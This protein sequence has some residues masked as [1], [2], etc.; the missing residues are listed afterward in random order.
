MELYY[1]EEEKTTSKKSK[2]PILIGVFI[3][4]LILLTALI[5]YFILYL[6]TSV[7]KVNIDGISKNDFGKI[8]EISETDNGTE[9]YFPIRK[10][11][12]Y[13]GYSDYSG[14]YLTKSE[15]TTKCYVDNNE[16]IAM[17]TLNSNS[18]ILIRDGDLNEE[19]SI[20]KKIFEKDNELYTTEDGIEK[21]FNLVFEYNQEKNTINIY[22]LDYLVSAYSTNLN[23]PEMGEQSIN[24]KKAILNGLLI[25][26]NEDGNKCGVINVTTGKYVLETKYDSISYLPYLKQFLVSSNGKYGVMD[27]NG[28]IKLKVAYDDIQ[29]CDNKN[30][31]YVVK[32]NALY[33][34]VDSSGTV[35]LPSDFDKIGIDKNSFEQNRIDN[36]YILNSEVIPVYSNGLWGFYNI[37]G[38]KITN[39][40]YTDVGC[41]SVSVTNAYPVVEIPSFKLIV[42]KVDQQHY[43][44]IDTKGQTTEIPSILDSVY[45][46]TDAS[47]GKN[48]YYISY[49]GKV[50][51][52]EQ[53]FASTG[54]TN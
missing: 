48:T 50:G 31:L 46:K 13:F 29:V 43:G 24:D 33:G 35:I 28:K 49:N 26:I 6:K 1:E 44:F 10:V 21:A 38:E 18:V 15:D 54:Y 5:L 34:I 32:E 22:T 41:T 19:V 52:L 40:Q 4:I 23:L 11:A 8:I 37:K 39:L 3:I 27:Q 25:T 42:V 47:T 51:K 2:L 17:F 45:L 53:F 20:D 30:G 16:E 36:Q 14:D 9:I 12:K 7:L